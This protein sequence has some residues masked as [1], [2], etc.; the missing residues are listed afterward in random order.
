MK[1]LTFVDVQRDRKQ[2]SALLD[3]ASQDDVEFIICAGN[4][5]KITSDLIF[6]IEKCESLGKKIYIIPSSIEERNALENIKDNFSNYINLDKNSLT[7]GNYILCGYGGDNLVREDPIFRKVA[8]EWYSSHHNK[9]IILILNGPPYGTEVDK[10][11]ENYLGNYDYRKFV[12]RIK[13][14]LVICGSIIDNA[15]KMD[16]INSTKVINP[17]FEGMVVELP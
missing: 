7:I 6:F 5:S 14:A 12:D 9:K 1:F 10:V 8:R 4:L 16:K 13:P 3:R 17:G 15:G 11:G 2:F